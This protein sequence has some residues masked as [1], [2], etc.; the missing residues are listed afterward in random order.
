MGTIPILLKLVLCGEQKVDKVE[1]HDKCEGE[2]LRGSQG[3]LFISRLASTHWESA[4]SHISN[5]KIV[6]YGLVLRT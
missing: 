3:L 2:N 5:T 6:I 4:N 1:E